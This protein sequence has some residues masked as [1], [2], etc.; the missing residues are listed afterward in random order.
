[1]SYSVKFYCYDPRGQLLTVSHKLARALHE[2]TVTIPH[3][4]NSSVKLAELV[5]SL[6]SR[7]PVAVIREV[8][9]LIR[10]RPDGSPDTQRLGRQMVAA[11]NLAFSPDDSG[12]PTKVANRKHE[13]VRRGGRWTPKFSERSEIREVALGKRRSSRLKALPRAPADATNPRG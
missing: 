3:F 7:K 8:Y 12:G 5:V 6:E 4:A 9:Y 11:L 10:F 1:M 2:G 13:F